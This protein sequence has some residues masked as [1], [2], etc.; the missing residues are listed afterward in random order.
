MQDLKEKVVIIIVIILLILAGILFFQQKQNNNRVSKL[1]QNINQNQ[2]YIFSLEEINADIKYKVSIAK[3]E[4]E[5]SID[6]Y[7]DGEHTST[8]MSK[9]RVYSIMHDEQQYYE[10]DSDELEGDFI[11]SGLKEASEKEYLSGTETIEGNNYYYEEYENILS[12]LILLKSDE[13]SIVKTKFYF[14]GDEI[15]FIKNVIYYEDGSEEEEL[16]SATLDNNV[17]S[18]IFEIPED[19][20]EMEVTN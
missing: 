10:Y 11:S 6:F 13:H 15:K 12:F 5:M 3:K 2:E 7:T 1:Y 17:D 9:G 16:L 20:A 19:Y 18:S 8:L 14:K 4:N